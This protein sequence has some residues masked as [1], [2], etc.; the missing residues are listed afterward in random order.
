MPA[1]PAIELDIRRFRYRRS[2]SD[3]LTGVRLSVPAGG[4]LGVIG[5]NRAG[6]STLACC[7]NRGV[8]AFFRGEFDGTVRLN[9]QDID[10]RTMATLAQTVGLVFQDFESQLF[11]SDVLREC[12]FIAEN[13]AVPPD[14]IRR[15]CEDRLSALDLW[16]RRDREPSSLSGGQKQRLAL[17]CVLTSEP[18]ILA[19]DEPT[20]DLDGES[21]SQLLEALRQERDA[22]R[23]VVFITHELD[24]LADA[25]QVAVMDGGR[26][27]ASGPAAKVLSDVP[28]LRGAGIE[29]PQLSALFHTLELPERPRTVEEAEALL[30]AG[31]FNRASDAPYE[32]VPTQEI[33]RIH[34]VRFGYEPGKA[35]IDDFDLSIQ[36][37]TV[38]A[39]LGRNGSGK[40][41]LVK[42]L[43]GILPPWSGSVSVDGVDLAVAPIP[44][45]PSLVG[46]VFQNPDHQIFSQTVFEEV[47]FGP[48]HQAISEDAVLERVEWAL[49]RAGLSDRSD[50]DPFA[51]TKGER[52][53]VALASVLACRPRLLILDEPTT[54]LDAP[55]RETMMTS[56]RRL[57]E[58][59]HGVLVITHHIALACAY[60]DRVALIDGGRRLCDAPSAEVFGHADLVRRAGLTLPAAVEL[61]LRFGVFARGPA[62]LAVLLRR[63]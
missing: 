32:A 29:P 36:A 20:T 7:L 17:A 58:E 2:E 19:L 28:L 52:K 63:G 45:R 21:V 15:R 42:I 43:A 53:R 38:T 27:V 57:A 6:K 41:T 16:S 61:G 22:G 24:Q 30:R 46:L 34:N 35:V 3:A 56:L 59:G 8:P 13:L 26:M 18:S 49:E 23:T 1:G 51:M 48:R 60:A 55:E 33:A 14:E 31:G 62:D 10:G 11:S 5:R 47:A 25:D 40:T 12:A 4:F 54:G 44:Q 39:L 37:G 9:G 50:A